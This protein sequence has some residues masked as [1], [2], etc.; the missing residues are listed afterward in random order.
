MI[1]IEADD[2]LAKMAR[3]N[4]AARP[5]SGTRHKLVQALITDR[6]GVETEFHM[7]S[8][9]GASS[10]I[11][12]PTHRHLE[13]FPKVLE[14]GEVKR[15]V[16]S[17]LDTVLQKQG[18]NPRDLELLVIDVQGAELLCLNGAGEYLDHPIFVEI[19]MSEEEV[20]T[21]GALAPELDAILT[22][23]GFTRVSKIYWHGDTVHVRLDRLSESQ[24]ER[25]ADYA[26]RSR[27][28]DPN[29]S[30]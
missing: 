12:R 29:I 30:A 24:R 10:S 19:E 1:W 22:K 3:L 15:F 6:D 13:A 2:R 25:L 14:T 5:P 16:S 17:R 4:L 26:A 28:R 21:G 7:M 20:Y 9:K 8:N 11:F 27:H 23:A 18:F